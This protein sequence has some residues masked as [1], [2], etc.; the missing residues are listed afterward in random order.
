MS[1]VIVVVVVVTLVM[2]LFSGG[3]TTSQRASGERSEEGNTPRNR[4]RSGKI[5]PS[6]AF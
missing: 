5:G 6:V 3:G 2:L 1:V 4:T